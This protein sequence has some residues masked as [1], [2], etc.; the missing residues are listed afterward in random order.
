MNVPLV[1]TT[2]AMTTIRVIK[3]A[4]I[5]PSVCVLDNDYILKIHKDD[6]TTVSL[7]FS[8]EAVKVHTELQ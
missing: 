8:D 6:N 4:T 7:P 1:E 2:K 5:V 3:E